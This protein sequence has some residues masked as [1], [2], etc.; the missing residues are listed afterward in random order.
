MIAKSKE[1]ENVLFIYRLGGVEAQNFFIEYA[2]KNIKNSIVYYLGNNCRKDQNKILHCIDSNNIDVIINLSANDITLDVDFL[3]KIKSNYELKLIGWHSDIPEYFDS[4]LVYLSQIYDMLLLDEGSELQRYRNYGFTAECFSHGY[5]IKYKVDPNENRDID[6]AFVGRMDRPGRRALFS[7][8]LK[9]GFNVALYGYGTSNGY[10]SSEKMMEVY[11]RSKIILN[12][13]NIST[14][15]PHFDS[16]RSINSLLSQSKGR[17]SE[18]AIAGAMIVSE[19]AASLSFHGNNGENYVIFN[20]HD[21]LT[22]VIDYYIKNEHERLQIA[23]A[24]FEHALK[25]GSYV[26][27]TEQLKL[28]IK[29]T[30]ISRIGAIYLDSIYHNF[31][32]R[33]ILDIFLRELIGFKKP[34]F[35]LLKG[36]R[37]DFL[38]YAIVRA[39]F[40][41]PYKIIFK[42]LTSVSL[43]K[44]KN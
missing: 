31:V 43:N 4:F 22:K 41:Y 27:Q 33:T 25:H 34:D 7:S 18:G 19:P 8:L 20:S 36:K 24:G 44:Y 2:Q 40:L 30:S 5:D 23:R 32:S 37:V 1:Y 42:I 16:N 15:V 28:L 12:L 9:K 14:V 10:I 13:T 11:A 35:S 38:I 26:S 29:E 6:V 17:I 3:F 39:L 21:E